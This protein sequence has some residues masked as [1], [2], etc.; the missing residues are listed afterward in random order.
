MRL[1]A[2]PSP[3]AIDDKIFFA[4]SEEEG[5]FVAVSLVGADVELPKAKLIHLT[6]ATS[7]SEA[8]KTMKYWSKRAYLYDPSMGPLVE[9]TM[10][11]ALTG[12]IS[13]KASSLEKVFNKRYPEV[14]T[15]TFN[16]H[17]VER[18]IERFNGRQSSQL[19]RAILKAIKTLKQN[20][21]RK[22]AEGDTYKGHAVVERRRGSFAVVTVWENHKDE[23]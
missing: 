8:A 14:G 6:T 1:L 21:K 4:Y 12:K 16:D 18:L 22:R 15:V 10:Y 3:P 19:D 2:R 17:A 5:A 23:K 7:A 9:M 11:E 13:R 20:P